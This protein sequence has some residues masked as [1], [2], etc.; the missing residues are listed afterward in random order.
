MES[1]IASFPLVG[2]TVACHTLQESQGGP[3][4]WQAAW[5]ISGAIASSG[6]ETY[7]SGPGTEIAAV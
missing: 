4:V 6:F 1:A 5:R 3:Q 2:P 7:K